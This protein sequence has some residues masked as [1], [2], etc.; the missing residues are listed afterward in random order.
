M[1]TI[2]RCEFCG[3]FDGEHRYECIRDRDCTGCGKG[4]A[5]HSIGCSRNTLFTYSTPQ[6]RESR[7]V[8]Y[9]DYSGREDHTEAAAALQ[10]FRE[11]PYQ[12]YR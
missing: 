3:L 12:Q 11:S 1:T 7:C 9:G 10:D 6:S 2:T 5:L 4:L 8:D